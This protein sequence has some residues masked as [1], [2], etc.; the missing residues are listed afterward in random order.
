MMTSWQRVINCANNNAR[1]AEAIL[2]LHNSIY[3]FHASLTD[4]LSVGA[5]RTFT[6]RFENLLSQSISEEFDK[7]ISA[8]VK[9]LAI[10]LKSWLPNLEACAGTHFNVTELKQISEHCV[11]VLKKRK[12]LDTGKKPHSWSDK[13]G[14]LAAS[15]PSESPLSFSPDGKVRGA[16]T[17]N[18][19]EV[20]FDQQS[21]DPTFGAVFFYT[22]TTFMSASDVVYTVS[23]RFRDYV[24]VKT[25]TGARYVCL[26][27]T[28]RGEV[29]RTNTHGCIG[30]INF[31]SQ[32]LK[33]IARN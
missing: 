16:T 10:V 17:A 6:I 5:A 8:Y 2:H 32:S 12:N 15:G 19:V 30:S 31:W 24:D 14:D 26:R 22:F 13:S 20:L 11:A 1:C 3:E 28:T 4:L 33:S 18:L 25:A 21:K 23:Q 27:T 29:H 9:G 7:F